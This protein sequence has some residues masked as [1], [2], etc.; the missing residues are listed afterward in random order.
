MTIYR[1]VVCVECG[2]QFTG[3]GKRFCS[4]ACHRKWNRGKNHVLWK[5]D[6]ALD[7]SK[8]NRAQQKFT[9]GECVSCGNAA[10][11][12]HHKD[13]DPGN[14]D[15]SNIQIL[16][17]RCH[18]NVDGRLDKLK[19]LIRRGN[20]RKY[21]HCIVCGKEYYP[22]RK[23][24]CGSCYMYFKAHGHEKPPGW[25]FNPVLNLRGAGYQCP[26]VV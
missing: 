11:D 1:G 14:N 5:G 7:H 19:K 3:K 26:P 24:K 10:T 23:G 12:R 9:L 2:V 18:M 6:A 17:R 20:P 4:Y 13:G 21:T 25:K 15:S 22:T 8:R 16:C